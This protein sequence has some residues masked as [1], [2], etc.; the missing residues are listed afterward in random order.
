LFIEEPIIYHRLYHEVAILAFGFGL[1][2]LGPAVAQSYE[3]R[4]IHG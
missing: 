1:T 4:P 3:S 2:G